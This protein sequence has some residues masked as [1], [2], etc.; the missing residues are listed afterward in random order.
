MTFTAKQHSERSF[1]LE[2]N[3]KAIEEDILNAAEILRNY[4]KRIEDSKR[5][6][7]KVGITA[8]RRECAK[9]E[10]EQLLWERHQ[11]RVLADKLLG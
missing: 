5:D 8:F 1:R 3:L 10:V 7:Y 4:D 6:A 2:R 9:Q 11:V